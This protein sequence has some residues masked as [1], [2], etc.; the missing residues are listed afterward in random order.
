YP[1][2]MKGQE[3]P[4][5]TGDCSFP[6]YAA[7]QASASGTFSYCIRNPFYALNEYTAAPQRKSSRIF[8]GQTY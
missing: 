6:S 2:C 5:G 4:S 1:F 8:S 7:C 3:N